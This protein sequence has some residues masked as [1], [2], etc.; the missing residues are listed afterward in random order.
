MLI[1]RVEFVR[2]EDRASPSC[3]NAMAAMCPWGLGMR[4]YLE[5]GSLKKQLC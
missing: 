1:Q 3:D 5:K 4:L 2:L